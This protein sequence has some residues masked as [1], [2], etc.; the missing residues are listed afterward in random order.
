MLPDF[1]MVVLKQVLLVYCG[2]MSFRAIQSHDAD[3][4]K[5]WLTFW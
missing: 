3:D 5:R 1:I 4:D 2:V